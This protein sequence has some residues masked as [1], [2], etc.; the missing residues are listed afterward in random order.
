MN[1]LEDAPNWP[2]ENRNE[3]FFFLNGTFDVSKFHLE[4]LETFWMRCW[5]VREVKLYL[6]EGK[7]RQKQILRFS[8][9]FRAGIKFCQHYS[10]FTG[11]RLQK[12]FVVAIIYQTFF[13]KKTSS[14]SVSRI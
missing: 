9:S 11:T 5:I 10:R 4:L 12:T 14:V 6:F 1:G 13:S 8:F 2:E 7:N 3:F